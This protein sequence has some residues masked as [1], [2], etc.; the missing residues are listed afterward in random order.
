[1]FQGAHAAV[2]SKMDL[3]GACDY[4]RETALAN[5]RRISPKAQVFELSAKTGQG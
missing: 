5:L 4:N 1:M 3:A 2:I